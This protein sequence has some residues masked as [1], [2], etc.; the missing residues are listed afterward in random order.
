MYDYVT[1]YDGSGGGRGKHGFRVQRG[2]GG[3]ACGPGSGR[4]RG[5]AT[6][7]A[8]GDRSGVVLNKSNRLLSGT[9]VCSRRHATRPKMK[10]T[11]CINH[12]NR[13]INRDMCITFMTGLYATVCQQFCSIFNPLPLMIHNFVFGNC[14]RSIIWTIYM[15]MLHLV[16]NWV[17]ADGSYIQVN[18]SRGRSKQTRSLALGGHAM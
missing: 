11:F 4:Q 10:T 17:L 7:V 5:G 2:D 15:T 16:A 14:H 12:V 6:T 3:C 13:R 18:A 9:T 8:R 1:T